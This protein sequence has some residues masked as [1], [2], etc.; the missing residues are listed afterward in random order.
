MILAAIMNFKTK[1]NDLKS[2]TCCAENI[3]IPK[4]HKGATIKIE[5]N[6]VAKYN[7]VVK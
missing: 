5:A 4:K 3:F 7:L 1:L 6:A 2:L